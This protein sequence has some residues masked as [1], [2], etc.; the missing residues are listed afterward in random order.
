[1]DQ[2]KGKGSP[3]QAKPAMKPQTKPAPKVGSTPAPGAKK[4]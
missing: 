2:Q 4:K 1:M 3:P